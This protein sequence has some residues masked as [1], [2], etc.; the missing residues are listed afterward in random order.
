MKTMTVGLVLFA[1]GVMFT[2]LMGCS[3]GGGNT[4]TRGSTAVAVGKTLYS[5][6][7]GADGVTQLAN[8]FGA[9]ISSNPALNSIL[10]GA[11]IGDVQSGLTND[12]MSAS[13]MPPSSSTTLESA[14]AGKNIGAEGLAALSNSLTEAGESMSL[15][16]STMSS[17]S[18]LL[19]PL[20]RSV[21]GM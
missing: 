9:N 17:L 8:Q 19:K 12:I 10:D 15:D 16:A 4:V 5:S 13:N 7:G 2:S 6:I 1:I 11:A 21:L 14:L 18:E 20:S 3:S